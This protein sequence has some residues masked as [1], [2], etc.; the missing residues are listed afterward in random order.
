MT[1]RQLRGIA[2]LLFSIAILIY[3]ILDPWMPIIGSPTSDF[4][5]LVGLVCAIAGLALV[6]KKGE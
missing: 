1:D 6:F 3:A 4:V 5:G 2:L